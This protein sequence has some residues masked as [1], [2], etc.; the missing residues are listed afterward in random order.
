MPPAPMTAIR[1]SALRPFVADW[2]AAVPADRRL[3]HRIEDAHAG[4]GRLGHL[5]HCAGM[6]FGQKIDKGPAR[7]VA[8]LTDL[9]AAL[10]RPFADLVIVLGPTRPVLHSLMAAREKIAVEAGAVAALLDELQLHLAGI[11]E[12]DRHLDIVDPAFVAELAQRQLLGIEPRADAA[13]LDPVAH[14]L[15]DVAD[16]DPDL[17]HRPEQSTH[18][19]SSLLSE[20]RPRPRPHGGPTPR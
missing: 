9:P 3:A 2:I 6:T 5:D 17:A 13:H 16:D 7:R 20:P 1:M 18:R 12:R 11:G 19:L 10:E 14:R 15:L 8:L 4:R